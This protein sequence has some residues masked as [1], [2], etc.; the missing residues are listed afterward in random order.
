MVPDSFFKLRTGLIKRI[1]IFIIR[2]IHLTLKSLI[3]L[4]ELKIQT[5]INTIMYT[6]KDLRICKLFVNLACLY[7]F[8][9]TIK[10]KV[11][12]LIFHTQKYFLRT[13]KEYWYTHLNWSLLLHTPQKIGELHIGKFLAKRNYNFSMFL[14]F[15]FFFNQNK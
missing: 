1:L 9:F 10:I 15:F 2:I 3:V 11:C 14:T 6:R 4:K 8:L 5:W 13:L 7:R 12:S